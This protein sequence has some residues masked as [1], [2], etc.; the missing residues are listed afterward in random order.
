[1]SRPV[2]PILILLVDDDRDYPRFVREALKQVGLSHELR[3]VEDGE[4]ALDY[5]LRRGKYINPEKSPRPGL[6]FLDL[7]MPRKN[8]IQALQEIRANS[9]IRQIPVIMLTISDDKKDILLSYSSG[10]NS[11]I[12]KPFEFEE[13]VKILKIFQQYWFETVKLP[14]G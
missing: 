6:I 3:N 11:F 5:L 1:M 9:E 12:T 4:E 2:K 8:G 14:V 7:N 10:A 13:L